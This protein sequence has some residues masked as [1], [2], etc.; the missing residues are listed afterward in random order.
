MLLD[1][2]PALKRRII[3]LTL[4]NFLLPD[5]AERNPF[6]SGTEG[7]AVQDRSAAANAVMNNIFLIK[8]LLSDNTP[9]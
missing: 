4:Q 2:A 8:I 5:R 3:L 9:S 7:L 1:I 6:C